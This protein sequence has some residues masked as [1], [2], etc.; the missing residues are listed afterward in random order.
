M[1]AS[2]RPLTQFFKGKVIV[3]TCCHL[4]PPDILIWQRMLYSVISWVLSAYSISAAER[5]RR[6]RCLIAEINSSMFEK[7]SD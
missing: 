6:V 5:P 7:A 2:I 1:P 3:S 4:E